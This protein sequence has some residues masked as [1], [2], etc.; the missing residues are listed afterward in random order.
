MKRLVLGPGGTAAL[1]I[2]GFL[3]RLEHDGKIDDL[4]E[5][6]ASSAGA[7][8]A[9]CFLAKFSV[10]DCLKVDPSVLKPQIKNIKLGGLIDGSAVK[11]QMK[12][13]ATF[14]EMYRDTGIKLHVAVTSLDK[15]CCEYLSVDTV[16]EMIVADAIIASISVP[17]MF[18][19]HMGYIDGSLTEELPVLPFVGRDFLAVRTPLVNSENVFMRILL[20]IANLRHTYDGPTI[21]LPVLPLNYLKFNLTHDDKMRLLMAGYSAPCSTAL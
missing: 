18:V 2:F 17:F 10:E 9:F 3:K 7:L 8:A 21:D 20:I 13:V 14:N 1:T 5:I 12:S 11:P 15:G 19:P 6:S 16:P 4:E